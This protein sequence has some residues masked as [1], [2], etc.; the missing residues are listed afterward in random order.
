MQSQLKRIGERLITTKPRSGAW[1]LQAG[2]SPDE[3]TIA[4]EPRLVGMDE[5]PVFRSILFRRRATTGGGWLWVT[6]YVF[7]GVWVAA[8]FT[9]NLGIRE[10]ALWAVGVLVMYGLL[11]FF[12]IGHKRNSS[13]IDVIPDQLAADLSLAAVSSEVWALGIWGSACTRQQ[14]RARLIFLAAAGA[15]LW[16]WI[17][18]TPRL[19]LD[20]VFSVIPIMLLVLVF[21]GV[22]LTR[23]APH[24]ALR[25]QASVVHTAF[26]RVKAWRDRSYLRSM[27]V[28]WLSIFLAYLVAVILLLPLVLLLFLRTDLE[29]TLAEFFAAGVEPMWALGAT[30]LGYWAGDVRA[31]FHRARTDKYLSRMIEHL[32]F[33]LPYAHQY[34]LRFGLSDKSSGIEAPKGDAEG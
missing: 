20:A 27:I 13:L 17:L 3:R 7:L 11:R 32:D 33:F 9:S 14:V 16:A 30:I 8:I 18:I 4:R 1:S 23:R 21:E 2:D 10:L 15:L 5:N 31:R 34:H 29:S 22:A 26:V 19:R 24:H 12:K 25:R 28:G 6:P